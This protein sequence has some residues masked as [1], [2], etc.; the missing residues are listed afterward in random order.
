MTT[1]G[2]AIDA[3]I[4]A[5]S[6]IIGAS[7][8]RLVSQITD[9]VGTLGGS[10]SGVQRALDDL[11]GEDN[12]QLWVWFTDTTGSLSAPDFATRTAELSGFGGNDLL[13]V[14]AMSDHAYGYWKSDSIPLS[15]TQLDTILGADLEPALKAGDNAG[16]IVATAEGIRGAIGPAAGYIRIEYRVLPIGER[17]PDAGALAA[18]KSILEAR[19]HAT[20]IAESIVETLGMDRVVVTFSSGGDVNAIRALLVQTGHFDFVP[21]PP[22]RYGTAS[23]PGTYRAVD[24]QP[25]PTTE[26]PLFGGEEIDQAYPSTDSTGGR[27]VGFRLKSKGSALFGDY[28][29]KNIGNFFA[30]VLDNRVVSAPVIQG[31]IIGGSG[32][33]SGG[34]GGGFSAKEMNSLITVL[35]YGSLPFPLKE[36]SHQSLA[37]PNPASPA[38]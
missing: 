4:A 13:L 33:I 1:L 35:N 9:D 12:V 27:A 36:E 6:P 17:L 5:A 22:A 15:N 18:T 11:Q 21:L 7:P 16:A 23:T 3:L 20:G 34:G 37:A 14:V 29:S 19:L 24:G 38:P 28:T 31:A 2:P 8:R 32:I 25:L 26:T 10:T 30:I